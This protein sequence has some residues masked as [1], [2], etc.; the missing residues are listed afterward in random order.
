MDDIYTDYLT[1]GEELKTFITDTSLELYYAY[2]EGKTFLFE[3]AQG[4]SLD[5]DHGYVSSHHQLYHR[6]R[7]DECRFWHRP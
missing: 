1:F 7:S 5:I 3:A 2:K 4:M 6:S